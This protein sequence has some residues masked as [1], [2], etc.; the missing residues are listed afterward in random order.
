MIS[1]DTTI[2]KHRRI[3]EA[4]QASGIDRTSFGWL[5]VNNS[6]DPKER[7]KLRSQLEMLT[8]APKSKSSPDIC[9]QV[10]VFL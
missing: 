9:L 4:P 1:W 2:F 5:T 8:K 6:E 3:W 7:P 10:L